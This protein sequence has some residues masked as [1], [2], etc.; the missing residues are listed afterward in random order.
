MLL[1]DEAFAGSDTIATAR[2]LAAVIGREGPFDLILTGKNSLDADTGQVPP[3]LAERLDIPFASGVKQLDLDGAVLR[4]GCEHDDTRVELELGLPALLSC[5]ER[6]CD[7]AK[8]PPAQ[9]A[10][11]PSEF[12]RTLAASDIGPGPWGRRAV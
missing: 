11:V 12:I 2:A 4:V 6:L 8:V 9:R 5:A 10:H 7:P 1:C 3:Q